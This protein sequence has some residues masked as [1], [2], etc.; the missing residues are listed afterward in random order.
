M[1][2]AQSNFA[3]QVSK[4]GVAVREG[5]VEQFFDHG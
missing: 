5:S 1:C 4:I 2:E 3:A